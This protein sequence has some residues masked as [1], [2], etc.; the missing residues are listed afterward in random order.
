MSFFSILVIIINNIFGSLAGT[1]GF[2][3][4]PVGGGGEPHQP[5]MYDDEEVMLNS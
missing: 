1:H 3:A 2:W 5:V 4:V